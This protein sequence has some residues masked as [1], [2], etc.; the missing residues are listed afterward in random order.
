M[1]TVSYAS[2]IRQGSNRLDQ[3]GIEDP[4]RDSRRIL[5]LAS[6]LTPAQLIVREQDAA[7]PE[8]V[9][10]YAMMLEMRA[11]RTPY[12]HIAGEIEFYGLTMRCD[13]R[14]LIPRAD[15]EVVVDLALSHLP[16]AGALQ[17]ADLGTGTGALLAALLVNRPEA[18]GIAIEASP[19]AA[20]LA[21]ENFEALDVTDRTHLFQGSW[22]DWTGWELCDLIISNP[23]YIRSQVI[24][25]LAPEV[26]DYDPLSALDGGDDGL[27]AYREII[28][29]AAKHMKPGAVIVLEIG[30]DQKTDVAALLTEHGFTD[31]THK[32]DLG[33]NDRVIAATKS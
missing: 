19:A 30:F 29:L 4:V 24:S 1:T 8:H 26:R 12:A 32:L 17:I 2:L 9:E 33:G 5:L 10:A 14:A 31:L 20:G 13:S 21:A 15:S 6:G 3:A 27:H 11:D 23:P 7:I 16:E 25:T 22:A 18:R 28:D